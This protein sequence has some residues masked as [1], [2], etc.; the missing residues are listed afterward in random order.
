MSA[1]MNAIENLDS[2]SSIPANRWAIREDDFSH[3]RRIKWRLPIRILSHKA[4]CI[5][6][7]ITSMCATLAD[8][9]WVIHQIGLMS[10]AVNMDTCLSASLRLSTRDS[11]TALDKKKNKPISGIKF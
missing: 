6:G 8:G 9:R 7:K 4:N 10:N 2:R 3:K 11:K 1:A 5:R